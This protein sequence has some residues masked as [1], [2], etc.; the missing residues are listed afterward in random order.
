MIFALLPASNNY[1][2]LSLLTEIFQNS[3]TKQG[4]QDPELW[5]YCTYHWTNK[6][7]WHNIKTVTDA[8]SGPQT[9]LV[10]GALSNKDNKHTKNQQ[11]C[12]TVTLLVKQFSLSWFVVS[13]W[14]GSILPGL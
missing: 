12:S 8:K 4:A 5:T 9:Q 11:L 6:T 1:Q 2:N 7:K 3:K 13:F 10:T 14:T